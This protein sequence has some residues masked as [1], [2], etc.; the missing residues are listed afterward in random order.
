MKIRNGFVSNSSSSSFLVAFPERPQ[1]IDDVKRFLFGGTQTVSSY[2]HVETTDAI[3]QQI[4]QD[5]KG[6][7][8]LKKPNSLISYLLAGTMPEYKDLIPYD[9][10]ESFDEK[11]DL[12]DAV[13]AAEHGSEAHVK[14]LAAVHAQWDIAA[15]QEKAIAKN[16]AKAFVADNPEALIFEFEYCDNDGSFFS[17]MEHGG[18]FNAVPNLRINKH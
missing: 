5:I 11:P 1:D 12:Y 13:H 14:A 18:I 17:L 9:A 8:A 7:R 10:W 15:K 6:K 16:I 3:A 4:M 2:D